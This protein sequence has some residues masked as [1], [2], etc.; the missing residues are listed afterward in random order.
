MIVSTRLTRVRRSQAAL[1][2]D[3]LP[4]SK[5]QSGPLKFPDID[6]HNRSN[7]GECP[8]DM[9]ERRDLGQESPIHLP[10]GSITVRLRNGVTKWL[11]NRLHRV[12][13]EQR[14]LENG[15][16]MTSL[17]LATKTS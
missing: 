15:A 10:T 2:L 11:P 14:Q 16:Q 12:R 1:A 9:G 13:S 17:S 8:A 6:K 5:V 3:P 4:A 7:R